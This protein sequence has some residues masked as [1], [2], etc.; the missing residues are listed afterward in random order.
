MAAVVQYRLDGII[1]YYNNFISICN[2]YLFSRT[3]G[4]PALLS[5]QPRDGGAARGHGGRA[6]EALRA[7]SAT[8]AP[9]RADTRAKPKFTRFITRGSSVRLP[10]R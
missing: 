4:A 3:K 1:I 5:G 2:L 7:V 6:Q 8:P 10:P 9:I